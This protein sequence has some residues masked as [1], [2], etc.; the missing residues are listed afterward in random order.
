LVL[1]SRA[2]PPLPLARL[3]ARGQLSELRAAD[4]R[5][6]LAETAAFLREVTGLDLP[7][8]SVAALQD[9][10]EGWAAGGQLAALALRGHADAAGFIATFAG[11]NRYVLDFL[12]EEVLAGQPEPVLRFLL[13]TSVLD[14]LCGPL[15]DA[16][17]SRTDSQTRLEELER[18]N[19]FV[20]PLDE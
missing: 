5:F 20:V 2:E 10:A 3:R 8:A 4:L 15:C 1:S 17:T 7:P 18:A 11:S 14:R 9:R 12:T 19:L 13:Q 6:T 16:V